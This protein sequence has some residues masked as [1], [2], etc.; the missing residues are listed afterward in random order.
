MPQM[1]NRKKLVL[2][3]CWSEEKIMKK[4]YKLEKYS[5]REIGNL[6]KCSWKRT[7]ENAIK[8]KLQT[9]LE[10]L[11]KKK[12]CFRDW[13]SILSFKGGHT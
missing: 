7:V 8:A 6:S 3:K 12:K 11:K 10:R 4:Q 2:P 9:E 13:A 5:D 1:I